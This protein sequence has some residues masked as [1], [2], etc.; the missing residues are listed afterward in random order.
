MNTELM[1]AIQ[2]YNMP[3]IDWLNYKVTENNQLTFHHIIKKC[4]GGK[5]ELSNCALLTN[6]AHRYLHIISN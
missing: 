1:R 4:D 3:N 6:Y 5:K 2:F